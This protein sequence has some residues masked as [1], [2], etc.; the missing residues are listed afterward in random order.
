EAQK[1][2]QMGRSRRTKVVIAVMGGLACLLLMQSFHPY[3]FTAWEN[4]SSDFREWHVH[5][6]MGTVAHLDRGSA[7]HGLPSGGSIWLRVNG[8]SQ[9][10]DDRYFANLRAND[11]PRTLWGR[12]EMTINVRGE[13]GLRATRVYLR[14]GSLERWRSPR[15]PL[16]SA[17]V[18]HRIPIDEFERQTGGRTA[19]EPAPWETPVGITMLQLKVGYSIN[20]LESTGSLGLKSVRFE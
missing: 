19:W 8:F 5:V 11:P 16:T 17:W 15:I 18:E 7:T 14:S 6:N 20:D 10:A 9:P 12:D 3:A 4:S 1:S 2:R 13:G